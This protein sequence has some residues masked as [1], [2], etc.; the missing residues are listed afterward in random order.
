MCL[1]LLRNALCKK[2]LAIEFRAPDWTVVACR[3]ESV[4]P[5]RVAEPVLNCGY[6]MCR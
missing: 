6:T 5:D 4:N 1:N 3:V 2:W